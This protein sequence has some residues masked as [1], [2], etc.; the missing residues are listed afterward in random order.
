MKA[1]P[2][3]LVIAPALWRRWDWRTPLACVVTIGAL[4]F[5]YIS[6]GERVLGFLP[7]YAGEEGLAQGSG[8]WLLAGLERLTTL[9]PAAPLI[10]F[11]LIVAI[12]AWLALAMTT[13]THCVQRVAS[14]TAILAAGATAAISAHYFWYFVW[15]AVPSCIAPY[16]S[17]IF[18]SAAAMLLYRNSW[19][20]HFFW[21]C[22]LYIPAIVL[23]ALDLRRHVAAQQPIAANVIERSA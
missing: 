14:N 8:I 17:V 19:D 18:L 11:G 9:P 16:R 13:G 2:V 4:Y 1:T 23:A 20:E 12:F 22:L 5:C 15:L 21:P 6:E 3:V 10:Y 7:A